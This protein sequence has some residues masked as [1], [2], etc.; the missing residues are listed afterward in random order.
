MTTSTR[1]QPHGA[2]AVIT[3]DNPP[4]NGLGREL[5]MGLA[6]AANAT[7]TDP[8]TRTVDLGGKL[9]TGEFAR[10]VAAKLG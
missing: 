5:R 10:A 7:L 1:Y 8:A 3:L 2:V 4:V 6:G 9:S